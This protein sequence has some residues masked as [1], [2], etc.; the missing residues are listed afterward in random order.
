M[1]R[2]LALCYATALYVMLPSRRSDA[3]QSGNDNDDVTE[4]DVRA[5]MES[6]DVDELLKGADPLEEE[7]REPPEMF[8]WIRRST[9]RRRTSATSTARMMNWRRPGGRRRPDL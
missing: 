1:Q 5:W 8:S 9:T 6:A 2:L 3:Q 4:A 7:E